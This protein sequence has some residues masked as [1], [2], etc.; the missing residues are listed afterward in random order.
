M[1]RN[2]CTFE[3][4]ASGIL[5]DDIQ[6]LPFFRNRFLGLFQYSDWNF[7][8]S[9]FMITLF[10]PK[11]SMF[12]LLTVCHTFPLSLTYSQNFPGPEAMFQGFPVLDNQG[13]S[14]FSRTRTNP[15][16]S[17]PCCIDRLISRSKQNCESLI[18]LPSPGDEGLLRIGKLSVT[19]SDIRN[20]YWRKNP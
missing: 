6:I 20:I 7:Q 11:I 12:I 15:L 17:K 5:L 18:Y 14:R 19:A 2:T 9:K 4:L 10:F 3:W 16:Y 13:L 1:L 8:D